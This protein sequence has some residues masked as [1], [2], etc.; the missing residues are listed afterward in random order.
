MRRWYEGDEFGECSREEALEMLD[1]L[2]KLRHELSIV[3][4]ILGRIMMGDDSARDE[5]VRYFGTIPPAPEQQ[6][7][8]V[9]G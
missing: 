3:R 9:K 2:E 7:T 8:F 5:A 1:E 6:P 4:N